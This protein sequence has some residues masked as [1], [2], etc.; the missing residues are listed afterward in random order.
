MLPLNVNRPLKTIMDRIQS[1]RAVLWAL[2]TFGDRL[3]GLLGGTYDPLLEEGQV[4]PFATQLELFRKKLILDRDTLIQCD[5]SYRDQKAKESLFRGRRDDWMTKVNSDVVGLRQALKGIYSEEKLV[6]FGFARRT[7]QQPGELLEQTS[8]LVTRLRNPEL[9]LSGA[10]FGEFRFESSDL[11]KNLAGSVTG[12]SAS[13]GELVR[14]ERQSEAMKLAKDDALSDY[15][16]SFLWIARTVE[17]LCQL[18]GLEEVAR[19]VR[20]SSRRPGVTE[21]KFEEPKDGTSTDGSEGEL[22]SEG[23]SEASPEATAPAVTQAQ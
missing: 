2:G 19:R 3:V 10:R 4:T 12:L 21:K 6:E 22:S 11:A 13:V 20:P 16:K 1:C 5:R 8:H 9:D 14:E 23:S 7:P 18:A 15:N 17:S